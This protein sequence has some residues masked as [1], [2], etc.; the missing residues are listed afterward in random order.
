MG[1]SLYQ[2]ELDELAKSLTDMGHHSEI[3]IKKALKS[4]LERDVPLAKEVIA[5]DKEIDALMKSIEE[6]SL[7]IL[8]LDAPYAKDFLQVSGTLKMITDL[9]RIGDY[10]SDIAEEVVSF[11][12]NEPY[13]KKLEHITMMGEIVSSMVEDGVRY[14]VSQDVEKARELERR[15][16]KVDALFLHIKEELINKIKEKAENADQAIILMMIAKYLERIGDHAVNIGEWVDYSVTGSHQ[17][18]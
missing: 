12:P 9:E 5:Q 18:S 14:Y 1:E 16:D 2:N 10:A 15:D 8:L 13:I 17:V 3:A 7:R 11:P 6:K 4:L